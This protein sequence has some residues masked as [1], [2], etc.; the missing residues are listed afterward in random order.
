MVIKIVYLLRFFGKNSKICN[1]N[2]VEDFLRVTPTG[3]SLT[4]G[5]ILI[6]VPFFS[7]PFFHRTVILLTDYDS[8]SCA[9]LVL[10]K[11]SGYSVHKLVSD[12]KVEDTMYVG[13]PVMTRA[14]F[15]IHNHD[16]NKS[17]I[18]LLPGIYLGYDEI[19]LSLIEHQAISSL[20]YK[21]F[22][23]YAG[24]SR[25]QLE[26]EIAHKKWVIANANPELIFE[27]PAEKIWHSAVNHLGDEYKHWLTIPENI[28]DN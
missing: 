7:D 16:Q 23:G 24:W 14:V 19:F 27:T 5:R 28:N 18:K 21:F 8:E 15:C 20:R 11:V 13:G 2:F 25:G 12:I 6:A 1:M 22:L 10:N 26:D 17:S 3:L 4:A 9:G